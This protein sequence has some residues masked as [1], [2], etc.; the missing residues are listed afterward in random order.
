M[1]PDESEFLMDVNLNEIGFYTY[2][3][4]AFAYGALSLYLLLGWGHRGAGKWIVLASLVSCLWAVVHA[5][6]SA[7]GSVFIPFVSL[8][9]ALRGCVWIIFLTYLLSRIWELQENT[10]LR[11]RMII[12]MG[13]FLGGVLALELADVGHSFGLWA[14]SL[15][16][17]VSL[18]IKLIIS[19]MVFLLVENLYRNTAVEGRWGIRLLF[20]GVGTLFIYDFLLYSD[21]ILFTAI[22]PMLYEARGI[23]NFMIVPLI[24]L[25]AAR[26]PTWSMNVQFSRKAVFH[27]VTLMGS[28]AYLIG[29]AAAGYYLQNFAGKWG[30]IFQV[31]FILAALVGLYLFVSSGNIRATARVLLT[32][33]LFKYKYDYRE[34]WLHFIKTISTTGQHYELRERAIQALADILDCPGGALW[35]KDHDGG[36]SLQAK[37]N[38]PFDIEGE[39]AIDDAFARFLEQKGWVVKLGDEKEE[40]DLAAEGADIPVWLRAESQLWL[41][42]PLIHLDRLVG[43]AVLMRPR[44]HHRIGHKLDWESVD[45][46]KIVGRQVA[47]Y[48]AEQTSE[49]ALAETREFDAFNRRFAFVVHDIKNMASQLSMMVRNA[50]KHAHNPE[51][52]KD[53]VLTV[54][55]S[56]DKMN[57]LLSRIGVV[58][59]PA[60]EKSAGTVEISGFIRDIVDKYKPQNLQI[61]YQDN[62][63]EIYVQG[64]VES[65]DTIFMHII[66]NAREACAE[67]DMVIEVKLDKDDNYAVVKVKDNGHGMSKE[68]IRDELFRP[69]RSTKANGYGIGAY[70][71]REMIRRLGGSLKVKSVSGQG[72]TMIVYLKMLN[73]IAPENIE[74]TG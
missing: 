27:T 72:T 28:G 15:G 67:D 48:L 32:K 14:I 50:E 58:Q 37:W 51:F 25:S 10:A 19:I 18:Y 24:A 4:A 53:M 29:M 11:Q 45:L 65:L 30:D 49:M 34:E 12:M 9:E 42:L 73:E 41:L 1:V 31:T 33:H 46:M 55:N 6:S 74:Q 60:K 40:A 56:V 22:G 23:V 71:S 8:A 68:F 47:S 7:E 64:D 35:I 59:A 2:S 44:S 5:F 26:N 13:L 3:L 57:S 63:E 52:Q 43:F 61:A 38:F 70:E 69:F 20:L 66:E 39:L 16:P 36:Y 21:N 17:V 54:Q 62:G